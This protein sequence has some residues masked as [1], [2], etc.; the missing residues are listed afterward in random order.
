MPA[1]ARS[2]L[3]ATTTLSPLVRLPHLTNAA[4]DAV[5]APLQ[6]SRGN[7]TPFEAVVERPVSPARPARWWTRPPRV[8]ASRCSD[9]DAFASDVGRFGSDAAGLCQ[10]WADRLRRRWLRLGSRWIG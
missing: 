8:G 6:R 3:L 4:F 10:I 7:V 9:A 5:D 1:I 2:A